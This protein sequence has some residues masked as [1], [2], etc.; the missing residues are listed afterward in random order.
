[1]AFAKS[2]HTT[3]DDGKPCYLLVSADGKEEYPS[4]HLDFCSPII[5]VT[6]PNLRSKSNLRTWTKQLSATQFVVPR[7]SCLEVVYLL[8]VKFFKLFT[9]CLLKRIYSI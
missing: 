2:F 3:Y 7:P 5:V 8:Y 9:S 6:S 1:M 4:P